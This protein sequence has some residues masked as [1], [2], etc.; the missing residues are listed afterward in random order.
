MPKISL[1]QPAMSRADFIS[2]AQELLR[3]FQKDLLPERAQEFIAIN[4]GKGEYVLGKTP[5]EAFLAFEER[6]PHDLAYRCR[7]DGGPSVKFRS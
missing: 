5:H 7:A 3:G 6:W 2:R 1:K 4:V